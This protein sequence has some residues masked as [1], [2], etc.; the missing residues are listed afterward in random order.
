MSLELEEARRSLQSER[1]AEL[2]RIDSR[3]ENAKI[4]LG[5]HVAVSGIFNALE[6]LTVGSLRLTSLQFGDSK[7][8]QVGSLDLRMEGVGRTF[9]SVALQSDIFGRER[10]FKNPIFSNLALDKNGN[11][12]FEVSMAIDPEL[13][14]Y[15]NSIERDDEPIVDDQG[16]ASSTPSVSTDDESGQ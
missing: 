1:I 12:E 2:A 14:S 13:I 8:E 10:V 7:K 6:A 5:K 16:E 11:I 15:R 4:I 9:N 3:I